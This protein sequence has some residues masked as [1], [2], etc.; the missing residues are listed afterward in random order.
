MRHRR[1]CARLDGAI[2]PD[3]AAALGAALAHRGPDGFGVWRSPAAQ[4]APGSSRGSPSSIQ[5][6]PA[7]SRWRRARRPPPHRL[8]R[9]GSTTIAIC[10]RSSNRAASGSRPAATRKCCCGCS[11][12]TALSARAGPRHVRARVVG[13]RLGSRWSLARDRFGMK[14]L[15][16]A[17]DG[18]AR[19]PS[20]RRFTRWWRRAAWSNATDRSR[21]RAGIPANGARVPPSLTYVAGVESLAPG[22][23]MRWAPRRRAA[24]GRRSR[25]CAAVYARPRSGCSESDLRAARGRRRTAERGGAPGRRRARSA[26]F[27]RAASTPRAILSAAGRRRRDCDSTRYTVRFDDRSSGARARAARRVP[28]RRDAPRAACSTR[29][30]DRQRSRRR[31]SRGFDQPTLDAVNSHYVSAAVAETGIKAVL[32]GSGG[33]EMFGGYPSFRRLPAAMRWKR[34]I[35]PARPGDDTGRRVGCLPARLTE[36]WR[37]FM[38]GNGSMSAAHRTQRRPVA[39]PLKSSGWPGLRCSIA[40]RPRLLASQA[41]R[42]PCCAAARRRSKATSRGLETRVYLGSQLLRDLDAMSMAHGLEVRVPFVDHLLLDAVWPDLARIRPLHA[43]Q[44]PAARYA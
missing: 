20:H 2:E 8:Q 40:G 42:R 5:G 28:I 32:S 12:A 26:C 31:F 22:S 10:S 4:R 37:H 21:R 13:R 35:T 6:R 1:S 23:W 39:C 9:R 3:P 15:H 25:M 16:V 18:P 27:S 34:R 33:D 17:A 41:L 36:R 43:Q 14:P 11:R 19:S 38:A 44:A 24:F 29:I 30:A 7:R